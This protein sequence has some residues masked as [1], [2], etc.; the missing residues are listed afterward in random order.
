[1]EE[2]E[3]LGTKKFL[4]PNKKDSFLIKLLLAYL[5]WIY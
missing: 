5:L 1:M 3:I 4:E 2:Q